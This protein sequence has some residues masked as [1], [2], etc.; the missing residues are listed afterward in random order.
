MLKVGAEYASGGT[1]FSCVFEYIASLVRKHH[2]KPSQIS[3]ISIIFFTDGQDCLPIEQLE[4]VMQ[5]TS[6]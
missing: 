2:G 4:A 5:N 1:N 3:E 6:K